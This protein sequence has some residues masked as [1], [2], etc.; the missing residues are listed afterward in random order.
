MWKSR[1]EKPGMPA[2]PASGSNTPAYVPPKEISPIGTPKMSETFRSNEVAHIGKSV[3]VRGEL[4]GS[5]DLYVDGEVEGS[6]ELHDHS[7]VVG[8]NGRIRANVHAKDITIHGKVDGNLHG[9][10]RVELKK[11]AVLVG[12]I[13]TQRIVIEEG[14][15]F[16]GGI[17]I[18]K[19]T[20]KAEKEKAM[21][22]AASPSYSS[23]SYSSSGTGSSSSA[24]ASMAEHKKY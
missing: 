17:D 11:S 6:I 3:V 1:D 23:S 9:T 24:Q 15:Y 5:E 19:D 14:A 20:V 22:A 7:L 13:K 8:P 4:S 2:S 16:K 21:A 18:Q 12:D 10:D